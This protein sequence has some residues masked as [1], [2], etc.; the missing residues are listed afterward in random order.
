MAFA[1]RRGDYLKVLKRAMRTAARSPVEAIERLQRLPVTQSGRGVASL[2]NVHPAL[3]FRMPH[4]ITVELCVVDARYQRGK[5][6]CR[7][8]LCPIMALEAPS[9]IVG[10]YREIPVVPLFFLHSDPVQ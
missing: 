7:V 4:D 9:P 5:A 3:R 8:N 6:A 10:C 1:A 2:L